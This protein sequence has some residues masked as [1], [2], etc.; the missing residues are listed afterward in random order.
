MQLSQ[1]QDYNNYLN[2]L[3]KELDANKLPLAGLTPDFLQSHYRA[4]TPPKT[5]VQIV[6]STPEG[7]ERLNISKDK[8]VR[9]LA[10]GIIL[11]PILIALF[12]F[13]VYIA[14]TYG[15]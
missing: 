2:T 11:F 5:V 15:R 12:V 7:Q 3:R 13:G 10:I 8:S 9:A 14:F 4:K 6:L 1:D